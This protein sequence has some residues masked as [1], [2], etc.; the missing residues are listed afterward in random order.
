MAT[1]FTLPQAETHR[2]FKNISDA[3]QQS[4]PELLRDVMRLWCGDLIKQT[5]PKTKGQMVAKIRL[6]T[7]LLF[8]PIQGFESESIVK[9]FK[10]GRDFDIMSAGLVFR[11]KMNEAEMQTIRQPARSKTTGRI[12]YNNMGYRIVVSTR[13]YLAHN[14][15]ATKNIGKLKAGW[16]EAAQWAK[17]S[18]PTWLPG[19]SGLGYFADKLK[20]QDLSG[21]LEAGNAVPYAER[22]LGGQ[23]M[24]MLESKRAKDL[25]SGKYAMRWKKKMEQNRR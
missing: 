23:F 9:S 24:A 6:E 25:T 22:K 3:T 2:L 10:A 8:S 20:V 13:Q 12:R 11:P 19:L 18:I 4:I 7:A 21:Q 17:A 15:M 5:Y 1:T 14:R 16:K